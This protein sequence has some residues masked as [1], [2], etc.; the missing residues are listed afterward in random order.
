MGKSH[1][2]TQIIRGHLLKVKGKLCLAVFCLIGVTITQLLAPW[3]LK[4]V[5]DYILLEHALPP[6]LTFLTS[7]F[8]SGTIL[9][10]LVVSSFIAILAI[11][12]GGLSYFQIYTTT[13]IGHEL[14]Y[15]LRRELF[16]HLQRLSLS[17]HNQTQSGRS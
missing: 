9:P 15:A 5:L 11:L 12:G 1:K 8:Q 14:V 7:F 13:K 6:S 3:P 17:F 2:L 4:I 10:L 16:S